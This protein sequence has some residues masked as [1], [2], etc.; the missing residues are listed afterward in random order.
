MLVLRTRVYLQLLKHLT[1]Q[2]ILRQHAFDRVLYSQLR[3]GRHQLLAN[4]FLLT[5]GLTGMGA[6]HLL[7]QLL[8]GKLDLRRIHNDHVISHIH[9]GSKLR[10]VLTPQD[11]RHLRSQTTH[12]QTGSIN[13]IPLSV[14][15]LCTGHICLHR[16]CPLLD[17]IALRPRLNRG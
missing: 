12:R 15:I 10:L 7:L 13:N 8:T 17:Y 1:S 2:S 3:L 6:V 9:E 11:R 5:T 14:N 16:T 4:H